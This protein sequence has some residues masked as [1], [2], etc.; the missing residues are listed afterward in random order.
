MMKSTIHVDEFSSKMGDDADIIVLSFFVRDKAAARDLMAWFEKGYDY[1]IDADV[2]PG[3]IKPGRYLVYLEMRRR[4]AAGR[5]IQQLL[6]DLS[7]LTEFD[8]KDW[9]FT[10]EDQQ[11]PWSEE[12][13]ESVVPL[14]PDAYK[15]RHEE[16]LNE[17]RIA[18]G[19]N[20]KPVHDIKSDVR[21]LQSAAGIL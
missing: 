20:T 3:E 11:Y 2:S 8:P 14:T 7:T 17:M 15:D 19:L 4:S 13:F 10:Y 12:Q 9:T 5:H 16:D 18:A 21:A 6:D 1:V